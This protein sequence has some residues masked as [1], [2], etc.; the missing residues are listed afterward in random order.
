MT[1]TLRP[2]TG[3]QE[4]PGYP[5]EC[6]LDHHDQSMM[7]SLLLIEFRFR[8]FLL[9]QLVVVVVVVVVDVVT[10]DHLSTLSWLTLWCLTVLG[11]LNF[12]SL[13]HRSH[14]TTSHILSQINRLLL[15]DFLLDS[16]FYCVVDTD[17]DKSEMITNDDEGVISVVTVVSGHSSVYRCSTRICLKDSSHMSGL[18]WTELLAAPSTAR[19]TDQSHQSRAPLA[20]YT[21]DETSERW[22][23]AVRHFIGT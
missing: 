15:T 21:R 23:P 5:W 17:D 9:H 19:T 4:T 20:T 18:H 22:S 2:G 11:N 6:S 1:T 16:V 12:Y 10:A 14:L 13:T 8:I 7:L 3:D